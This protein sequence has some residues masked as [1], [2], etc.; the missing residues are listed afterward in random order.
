[1][2]Q[3][4]RVASV[5]DF[6]RGGEN[7][8]RR[9]ALLIVLVTATTLL[10][11]GAAFT[12]APEQ[13]DADPYI[14]VL[15]DSIAAPAQ[16]AEGIEGRQEGLEVGYVYSETI[17]GFSAQIPDNSVDEVRDNPRVSYVVR[18][19]VVRAEAQ[20]LPWGVNH[21]GADESTTDASNVNIYVI[22]TGVDKRHPD[23]NVVDH[24]SFQGDK[25]R[26]CDGHGTHVAGILAAKDNNRNVVGVAPGA[27]LTGVKVLGCQGDGRTRKI[28]K[29]I[30]WVTANA[31][32]P[33][34]ANVSL[35]GPVVKDD[36]ST[37]EEEKDPL[38]EA[39]TRSVGKGIFY[40]LAAGNQDTS[41]C[42][43]SPAFT[44]ADTTNGIVTTAATR[45]S[46]EEA[47]YSNHDLCVDLWAPGNRILST[48]LGGGTV[49]SSGTSMAAPHVG[50][51]AAL[52]LS[53]YPTADPVQ[54]ETQIIAQAE[55]TGATTEG[56]APAPLL[57]ARG[58]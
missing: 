23:L 4:G 42:R 1:M 16:M 7:S 3:Y 48:K 52:Y 35:S 55:Q 11:A 17:K 43:R 38:A 47:S 21:I 57:D 14:V 49:V 19:K 46:G 32:K 22:D 37:P 44:G 28:L 40:S 10:L 41:A 15:E 33:A 13:E 5:P 20:T 2:V 45:K 30:D 39:V 6:G 50:G 53:A 36:P 34:V 25:N 29:G 56:G 58:F 27:P 12:Q 18:D 26:D 31:E 54:V 24:V 8:V 51:T 9:I